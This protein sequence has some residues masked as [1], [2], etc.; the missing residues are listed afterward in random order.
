MEAPHIAATISFLN[1]FRFF[2]LIL[3]SSTLTSSDLTPTHTISSEHM[4]EPVTLPKQMSCGLHCLY[5]RDSKRHIQTTSHRSLVRECGKLHRDNVD[6]L[7]ELLV[8][9][10]SLDN[11]RLLSQCLGMG[12]LMKL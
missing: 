9:I 10:P 3:S 11:E 7:S 6:L 8:R 12:W 1:C 2:C 5:H 4:F